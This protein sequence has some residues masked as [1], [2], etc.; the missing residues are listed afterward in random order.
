MRC[1]KPGYVEKLFICCTEEEV[2]APRLASMDVRNLDLN[3]AA[4]ATYSPDFVS[5]L[6]HY[7]TVHLATNFDCWQKNIIVEQ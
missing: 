7:H 5:F 1:N 6:R 4:S 2:Y 3:G